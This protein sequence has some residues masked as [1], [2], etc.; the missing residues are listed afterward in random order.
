M[1][2]MQGLQVWEKQRVSPWEI[3]ECQRNPAPLSWAWFGA[4]KMER[5]TL[6][7][8]DTHRLLK[9]HTHGLVKEPSHYLEPVPLP[10]EE[11]DLKPEIKEEIIKPDTPMSDQSPRTIGP[12]LSRSN[13]K[14]KAPRKRRQTKAQQQPTPQQQQSTQAAVAAVAAAVVA[15]AQHQ[16]QHQQQQQQQQQAQQQQQQ[17]QPP[18]P[19]PQPPPPMSSQIPPEPSMPTTTNAVSAYISGNFVMKY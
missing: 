8:E 9:F 4:V 12:P 1:C 18:P 10:Q 17:Q 14:P 5:K 13:S 3:I 2:V 7:Y 16:Q 11:I 19:Q 15:N 6:R